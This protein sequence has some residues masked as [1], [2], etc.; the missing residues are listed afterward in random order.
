MNTEF[1]LTIFLL[2]LIA[3][4]ELGTNYTKMYQHYDEQL[5][6]HMTITYERLILNMEYIA[7]S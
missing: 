7:L 4:M 3:A 2:A 1:E 6:K 5:I